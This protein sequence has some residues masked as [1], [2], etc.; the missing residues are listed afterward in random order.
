MLR[1]VLANEVEAGRESE[2]ENCLQQ[3]RGLIPHK[4]RHSVKRRLPSCLQDKLTDLW[5]VGNIYLTMTP[6]VSLVTDLHGYIRFNLRGRETAGIVDSGEAYDQLCAEIEAGLSTF[7]D[8]DT[9]EPIVERVIRSDQA[10]P[11]GPRRDDLPDLLVLWTDTPASNHRAI[12]SSR[13]GSIPWP[14]PGRNPDGRSGN[15]RPEGFLI[16][17]GDRIQPGSRIEGAHILDLA[18]TVYALFD[19]PKP[20]DMCGK[21]LSAIQTG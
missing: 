2:R 12:T 6:A 15:H 19:L 11:P 17:A 8:A 1:R 18:P 9:R 14:T 4:W 21:A 16:A 5:R 7:V 20:A 13:Y 10:F 3:L